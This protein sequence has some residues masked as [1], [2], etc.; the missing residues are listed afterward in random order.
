MLTKQQIRA[1][2][3]HYGSEVINHER[4]QIEKRCYQHGSV[5]TFAHSIRVACL[6]VWLADR[7]RL[8]NRVD[9]KALVRS[10]LLHDYFLYD[11]HDWDNGEHRLHGFTHGGAAL[12]NALDDFDLND[13]ERDSISRHMFPLTPLPPRYVEGYLVTVA[14]KISATRETLSFDRFN[15]PNLKTLARKRP[16]KATK[17]S[18]SARIHA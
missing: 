10:A 8:W 6:S 15:R 5:T 7:L 17:S 2:V 13:I 18:G 4:M 16:V 11:W 9:T 3:H 12:L 14:D 1:L